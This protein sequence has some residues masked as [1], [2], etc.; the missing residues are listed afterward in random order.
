MRTI[1]VY[2]IA[3]ASAVG[4]LLAWRLSQ[5]LAGKVRERLVA[6]FY[7]WVVY[8]V[9]VPRMNGI[10]DVT[11]ITAAFL[12]A[13]IIANV[14]GCVLSVQTR[15]E[16]SLRLAKLCVTNVVFLYIGG[17]SNI[18]LDKFFRLSHQEHHL[19]HRWIGRVSVTEGLIHGTIAMLQSGPSFNPIDVSVSLLARSTQQIGLT[20]I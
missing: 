13:F 16:F 2:T 11:V 20:L 10:P 7:K 1:I 18:I 19:L 4:V 6:S 17:R 3:Y 5:S 15:V 9:I 12:A 8:S 14:V